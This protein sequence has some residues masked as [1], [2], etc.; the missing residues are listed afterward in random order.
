MHRRRRWSSQRRAAPVD[1]RS[2]PATAV[3][4]LQVSHFRRCLRNTEASQAK[5]GGLAPQKLLSVQDEVQE[6]SESGVQRA[7]RL[8]CPAQMRRGLLRDM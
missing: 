7:G 2:G 3:S 4:T 1:Q 5:G 8:L 6:A